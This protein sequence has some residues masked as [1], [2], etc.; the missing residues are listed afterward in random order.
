MPEKTLAIRTAAQN[1]Y[2]PLM[3]VQIAE[4]SRSPL[5]TKL[6]LLGA[7]AYVVWTSFNSVFNCDH[8]RT[9]TIFVVVYQVHNYP[10]LM[11]LPN[12]GIIGNPV[13]Y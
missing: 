7:A 6:M 5:I 8:V 11:Y 10:Y 13:I 1:A 4:I 9:L 12:G 3:A 2:L